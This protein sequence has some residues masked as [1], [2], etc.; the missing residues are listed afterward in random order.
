MEI[1][2]I[3]LRLNMRRALLLSCVLA[4]SCHDP[5]LKL[6]VLSAPAGSLYARKTG[7]AKPSFPTGG[8]SHRWEKASRWPLI[9]TD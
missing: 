4:F 5:A 7:T 8:S 2:D 6:T 9:L 3:M 1:V